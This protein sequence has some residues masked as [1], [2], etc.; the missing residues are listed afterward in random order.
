MRHGR[1]LRLAPVA[2]GL[3]PILGLLA[4]HVRHEAPAWAAAAERA[5]AARAPGAS[6]RA[7]RFSVWPQPALELE[8]LRWSTPGFSLEAPR[9]RLVLDAGALLLRGRVRPHRLRLLRPEIVL[10]AGMPAPPPFAVE[11]VYG[12]V[13]WRRMAFSDVFLSFTRDRAEV[14]WD[15][16][17]RLGRGS[18]RSFGTWP[19][20]GGRGY[21]TLRLEHAP[22]AGAARPFV[23]REALADGA[24][25]LRRNGNGWDARWE[26]RVDAGGRR[27]AHTRGRLRAKGGRVRVDE[28]FLHLGS[29][30]ARLAGGCAGARRCALRLH[31]AR[32]PAAVL[33]WLWPDEVPPRVIEGAL[34][35]DLE[36]RGAPWRAEG[37]LE[38]RGL[39]LG[40]G[41]KAH[42]AP[43]GPWRVRWER[44]AGAV[45]W[46]HGRL[47]WQADART[48]RWTLEAEGEDAARAAVL[49]LARAGREV[50]AEGRGRIALSWMRD[51]A[52]ETLEASWDFGASALVWPQQRVRKPADVPFACTVRLRR[53]KAR[54]LLAVSRCRGPGLSLAGLRASLRRAGSGGAGPELALGVKE[55]DWDAEAARAAG[56]ELG[57]P[58]TG[59][60]KSRRFAFALW[61][62]G[63]VEA[64][65]DLVAKGLGWERLSASCALHAGGRGIEG[66][67]CAL[68]VPGLRWQGDLRAR[69]DT[70]YLVLRGARARLDPW[71]LEARLPAWAAPLARWRARLRLG[72]AE[73]VVV[74]DLVVRDVQGACDWGRGAWSCGLA[75]RWAGGAVTLRDALVEPR[76]QGWLLDG[77]LRVRHARLERAMPL[78]RRL[79]AALAGRADASLWFRL[80][81]PPAFARLRASG[82][83]AIYGLGYRQGKRTLQAKKLEARLYANGERLRADPVVLVQPRRTWRGRLFVAP[84]GALEGAL[85][86]GR[87]R[88]RVAGTLRAP[89]VT[90]TPASSGTR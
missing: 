23:P 44:N 81:T 50:R 69:L 58:F 5:F 28:A 12:R 18:V 64:E 15:G 67:S 30:A 51:D 52:A 45:R 77:R 78:A 56:L 68:A 35:G 32:M 75:G 46:P 47:R 17:A 4:W 89:R 26:F 36:L 31:L 87:A 13:R 76:A 79:D 38:P 33:E 90:L 62:D 48:R 54:S 66:R 72:D 39:A 85:A 86:A 20:R 27:W 41:G 3:L 14:R 43:A 7:M 80:R 73:I 34:D 1:G 60:L 84:D 59:G 53:T 2:L 74:P 8:G 61:P 40:W 29:G 65:G 16:R 6:W 83:L 57:R 19:F 70:R 22:L 71:R 24:L 82:D 88:A 25:A 37:S 10:R 21:A 42:A 9:A 49:V 63:R 11:V 55:L